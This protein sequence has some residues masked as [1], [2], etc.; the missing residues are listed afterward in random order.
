[1]C[2]T[3]N[4]Q[5]NC[6]IL[7]KICD[8]EACKHNV[9]SSPKM[10][11]NY[12]ARIY[13]PDICLRFISSSVSSLTIHFETERFRVRGI[14][15]FEMNTRVENMSQNVFAWTNNRC[16]YSIQTHTN[17]LMRSKNGNNK[18]CTPNFTCSLI[19]RTLVLHRTSTNNKYPL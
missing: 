15:A 5:N 10:A 13:Q 1:M 19:F 4:G 2:F 12:C 3:L 9:H 11:W 14:I 18:N 17:L 16:N 6:T 8:T 7:F